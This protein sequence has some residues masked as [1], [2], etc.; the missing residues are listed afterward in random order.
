MDATQLGLFERAC[1]ELQAGDAAARLG[2]EQMLMQMRTSEQAVAVAAGAVQ[3]AASSGAKFQAA[4]ILRDS[5][6]RDWERM[7]KPERAHV[8]DELLNYTLTHHASLEGFVT[9]QLLQVVALLV[10]R[11][12]LD[13]APPAA[14]APGDSVTAQAAA[15]R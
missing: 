1:A 11:G 3:A 12:W 14:A 13:D 5:A 8:R 15:S 2:A 10:K 6:L 4:L 7:A 9:R